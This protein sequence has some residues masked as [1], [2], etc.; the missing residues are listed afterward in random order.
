MWF[1]GGK[2]QYFFSIVLGIGNG[3]SNACGSSKTLSI[4]PIRGIL[5]DEDTQS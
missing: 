3:E 5:V 2:K 1:F 4:F